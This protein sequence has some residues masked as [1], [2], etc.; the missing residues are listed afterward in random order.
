MNLYR[1]FRKFSTVGRPYYQESN[2]IKTESH[3][4]LNEK[5]EN[6]H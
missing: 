4:N 1:D 2:G 5:F 3:V 6:C